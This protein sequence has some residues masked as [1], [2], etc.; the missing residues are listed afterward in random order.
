MVLF[1]TMNYL[2]LII[3]SN[4]IWLPVVKQRQRLSYTHLFGVEE[5]CCKES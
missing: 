1:L 5:K 2:F 3:M 4:P